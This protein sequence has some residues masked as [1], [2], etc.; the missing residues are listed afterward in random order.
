VDVTLGISTGVRVGV[1]TDVAMWDTELRADV[2]L[3]NWSILVFMRYA[4]LAAVSGIAPDTDA[5]QEMGVGFGVGREFRWGRHTL[6]VTASPSVV[7]VTL[8]ADSP[9]EEEGELAQFR[10]NAAAR[11]GYGLGRGWRFTLTLDSEAAPSSLIKAR[12]ADPALPPVP[13]W[14]VGFRLGAAASL[15]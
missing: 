4:P 10:F 12:Y 14:T 1:P 5:Y 11:Y 9:M 15:L 3:R 6:D 8:E 2:L 7:F 13:A